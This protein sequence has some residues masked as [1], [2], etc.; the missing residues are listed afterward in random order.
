MYCMR[1][2]IMKYMLSLQFASSPMDCYFVTG[3][4]KRSKACWTLILKL[5]VLQLFFWK[6]GKTVPF[7]LSSVNVA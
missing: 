3:S 6:A 1:G 2:P 5:Y 4:T 7:M